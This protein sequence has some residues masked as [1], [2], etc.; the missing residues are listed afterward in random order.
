MKLYPTPW[1]LRKLETLTSKPGTQNPY[2][3]THD[4]LHCRKAKRCA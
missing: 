4:S 3:K 2:P 1:G